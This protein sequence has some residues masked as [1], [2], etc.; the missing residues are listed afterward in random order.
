LAF[1]L[2][3][4]I[5]LAL[6]IDSK[7]EVSHLGKVLGPQ[8]GALKVGPRIVVRYGREVI[9]DLAK[10]APVFVDLKFLDIPSTMVSSVK[11][12][13]DAGASMATVHGWS[14][15]EALAELYK[16]EQELNKMRPFIVLV[17]TILTSFKEEGLPAGMMKKSIKDHVMGL[18]DQAHK[19][20]LRGFV[21]SPEETKMI[22]E[23]YDDVFLVTPGVRLPDDEKG[24][25][26]RVMTPAEAM[27][28]GSSAL[29]IGRPIVESK[30]SQ[31][32]LEKYLHA[33]PK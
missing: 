8:V 7:S 28:N 2:K 23:K 14:G 3:N 24:D 33:I 18:V 22:K 17:V 32:A 25:Q 6:D 5:I 19:C 9:S 11:A 29:V 15:P 30:N 13:F 12:A 16:V 26:K 4:P 1:R 27:Q 31:G 10:S 20:G 21:C